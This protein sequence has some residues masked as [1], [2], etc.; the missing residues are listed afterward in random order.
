MDK[1]SVASPT[2]RLE[3]LLTTLVMDAPKERDTAIL[4][5]SGSFLISKVMEFILIKVDGE[6][7]KTILDVN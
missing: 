1:E 5:D 3:S 2:V 7:L 6:D 4:D